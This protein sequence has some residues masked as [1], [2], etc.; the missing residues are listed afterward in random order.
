MLQYGSRGPL[1][2]GRLFP[3]VIECVPNVRP[4]MSKATF[5]TTSW[6]LV[7]AAAVHPTRESRQALATLCQTYWLTGAW[8]MPSS[9]AMATIE[10]GRVQDCLRAPGLRRRQMKS[11][12][13]KS[14]R[15]LRRRSPGESTRAS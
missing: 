2:P 5:Q 10:S 8:S 15:A 6:S 4:G 13:L 3:F 9:G 14:K 7:L 12:V 1:P 11:L